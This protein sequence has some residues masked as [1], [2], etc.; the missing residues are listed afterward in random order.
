VSPQTEEHKRIKNIVLQQLRRTY[1]SGLV[2]YADSGN[3]DDVF[4]ETSSGV[5]IFVEIIWSP[6]RSNFH[7]DLNTLHNSDADVKIVIANQEILRNKELI[8]EYE[9]AMISERKRGIAISSLVDG[10]QILE[11]GELI[12]E[13]FNETVKKLVSETQ[14]T[15]RT[16]KDDFKL[17]L[18]HSKR[19]LLTRS[20]HQGLD[21]WDPGN[22]MENLVRHQDDWLEISC[23]MKHF[24]TGYHDSLWVHLTEFKRLME[25]Y[26]YPIVPYPQEFHGIDYGWESSLTEPFR[27]IPREDQEKLLESK[28]QFLMVLDS[29]I[30]DVQQG[31]PLRGSCDHCPARQV[32]R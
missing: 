21:H 2:E 20:D 29:V 1:G 14:R 31:S 11:N 32:S 16:R 12:G 17:Q 9:K 26:D 28:K 7:R 25:K 19:I 24:E 4:A 10:S 18:N 27:K 6:S 3:I 8:R 13:C 30:F 22:L 23:L 15:N 5:S